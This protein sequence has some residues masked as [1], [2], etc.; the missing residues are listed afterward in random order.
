MRSPPLRESTRSKETVRQWQ[1]KGLRELRRGWKKLAQFVEDRTPY[2][3]N[4]GAASMERTTEM[5]VLKREKLVEQRAEKKR[6]DRTRIEGIMAVMSEE[7]I[8]RIEDPFVRLAMRLHVLHRLSWQEVTSVIGAGRSASAVRDTC[9]C[10]LD[11][12]PLPG[13]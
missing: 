6:L 4:W 1:E 7:D 2:Y 3:R 9:C 12:H 5:I 10:Y 8:D 11:R 13:M